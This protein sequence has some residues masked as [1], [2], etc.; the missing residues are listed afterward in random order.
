MV[1]GVKFQFTL[2]EDFH[3]NSFDATDIYVL[4]FKFL[5]SK[6]AQKSQYASEV[7]ANFCG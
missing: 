4:P 3:S 7:S 1:C 6:L 5:S 2:V